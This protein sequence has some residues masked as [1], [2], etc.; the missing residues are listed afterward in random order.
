MKSTN[1]NFAAPLTSLLLLAF[2]II[3]GAMR[4]SPASAE[5]YHQRIANAA[6][7]LPY[8]I[9]DWVG[10]DISVP[11]A[12]TELLR[13]NVIISRRFQNVRTGHP[14]NLLLVQCRDSRDMLG[15]YPPIC[16]PGNGWTLASAAARVVAI[17]NGSLP[18]M[19]YE[20]VRTTG[21]QLSR[22]TVIDLMLLP[23]G[24]V[25]RTMDELRL[26]ARKQAARYYGAAQVQMVFGA[27]TPDS[28][29]DQALKAILD[30]ASPILNEI[31]SGERQ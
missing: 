1:M 12:A 3:E 29:R 18:A 27:E 25:V 20:F 24:R 9:D 19:E 13:P 5:P 30:A 22:L 23:D 26:A 15:H 11:A 14:V 2:L 17:T 7:K 4:T 16:Y 21:G 10:E 6:V 31:R 8:Q 28:E